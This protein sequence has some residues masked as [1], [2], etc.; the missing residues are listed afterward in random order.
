MAGFSATSSAV[1][2]PAR[3]L[4]YILA[5]ELGH[6]VD[7]EKIDRMLVERWDEL[8][9]YAHAHH[10]QQYKRNENDPV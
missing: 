8:S 5:E 2:N 3:T 1:K 10:R 9:F 7:S 6:H 4:A